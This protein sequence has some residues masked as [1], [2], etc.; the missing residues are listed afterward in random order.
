MCKKNKHGTV[1]TGVFWERHYPF[2][3]T[4]NDNVFLARERCQL[5]D[6]TPFILGNSEKKNKSC[7]F[8]PLAVYM[9]EIH[10]HMKTQVAKCEERHQ[11]KSGHLQRSAHNSS[12]VS[13]VSFF[14]Q[15]DSA[16]A[17]F[18]N[19][20]MRLG[21][22]RRKID[23]TASPTASLAYMPTQS[24]RIIRESAGYGT[25]LKLSR[26]GHHISRIKSS[27]QLFCTLVEI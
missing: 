15:Y 10:R 8:L 4:Q 14:R 22:N 1:R 19:D 27:F 18:C 13:V 23:R 11:G 20:N 16:S 3:T 24:S 12:N 5:S 6:S 26:T 7:D 21:C 9:Y 25:D 2:Y 17:I